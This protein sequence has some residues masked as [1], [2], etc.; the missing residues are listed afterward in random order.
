MKGV[1][2]IQ[3]VNKDKGNRFS[4]NSM[5]RMKVKWAVLYD[6]RAEGVRTAPEVM[7]GDI[8]ATGKKH[9]NLIHHQTLFAFGH[10]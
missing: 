1:D 2:L 8:V 4:D 3:L 7:R 5:L 10:C 6:R 9:K